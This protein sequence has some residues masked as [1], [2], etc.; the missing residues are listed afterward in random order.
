MNDEE[1]GGGGGDG[2]LKAIFNHFEPSD[3]FAMHFTFRR[4]MSQSHGDRLIMISAFLII[5]RSELMAI[6]MNFL[7]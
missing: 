2:K 5:V 1:D 7:E 4:A 3:A 6:I